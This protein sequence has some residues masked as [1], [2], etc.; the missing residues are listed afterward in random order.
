MKIKHCLF[1]CLAVFFSL[2][3]FAKID[4]LNAYQC[5]S[6]GYFMNVQAVSDGFVMTDNMSNALYLLQDGQVEKIVSAPGCGRYFT[7]SDDGKRIGFKMINETGQRPAV[8]HV[9][10]GNVEYLSEAVNLC[11]QPDFLGDAV[12][13]T[14]QNRL[15]VLPETGKAQTV[16][17]DNYSNLLQIS[18]NKSHLVFST[19]NDEL[20]LMDMQT[21]E[22]IQI[23]ETGKMSVYPQ[24]SPDGKKILFQSGEMFVYDIEENKRYSVGEGV[25]PKWSPNS[26]DI[27]F[28]KQLSKNEVLL[29]SDLFL[30][31]YRQGNHVALIHTSNRFEHYPVFLSENEVLFQTYDKNAIRILNLNSNTEQ[32]IYEGFDAVVQDFFTLNSEKSE[33]LIPGT[34]PYTHQVYDTPDEHY[35]YGSCAP[36]CA[37]M[38]I[39]YYNRLPKWPTDVTKLFPHSSDYGSYVSTKYR[40]NEHYFE[41]SSTT[42]GS[43]I[44]YGGYGYMWGLGSPNSQ[45]L[46]Y[47]ELHYFESSQ[48]WNSSIT[49]AGVIDEIDADYP[50]PM[51]AML[52]DAGHL[53]LTKGYI[54]DQHTLIF[55]EPYG[56]K[57][58]P[59]WP[60]Y[61]GH[62]AYYDWPGYNNGYQNLDH[63]G[64]YGVI[65]WTITAHTTETEYSNLVIDNDHYDHGFVM[66]NSENGSTQRYFRDV[67]DG[68]NNHAWYT[69]TMVDESDICYV[70]WIP[71]PEEEGF[72]EVSAFIPSTYADAEGAPY[73][74]VDANGEHTVILNQNDYS[75]EWVSLGTYHYQVG[76]EFYTYLGDST[77]YDGQSIAYDAVKYDYIPSPV[78][79]FESAGQD[80]CV[81]ESINFSNTSENA[82]TYTWTFDGADLLEGTDMNPV[83]VYNEAGVYDLSL[84]A[85]GVMETDTLTLSAYINVHEAPVADFSVSDNNLYLPNALAVFQN[86]SLYAYN[87]TWDFGDGNGSEDANPYHY[88]TEV[89]S[90]NVSLTASNPW[91]EDVI[92]SLEESIEV[93]DATNV[94]DANLMEVNVFPNPAT[95]RIQIVV[96]A[97]I[98]SVK[99]YDVNG[100]VVLQSEGNQEFLNVRG[101]AKGC[102]MLS[103]ETPKGVVRKQIVKE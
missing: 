100:S 8:Y 30:C 38:A 56:D 34:V 94:E 61:D 57:N 35:G 73:K 99:L 48:L 10:T 93:Q 84:L 16:L 51:C 47:L 12:Y 102:Y 76:S 31:D 101:L 55:S 19:S 75:D 32:L 27:V 36:T 33:D 80:F 65:A 18:P 86:E 49:W 43:D 97:E 89:G 17:L 58:T 90:F 87:Y 81:G 77:G 7:V 68:Y 95:D 6:K 72:Y 78:A 79:S 9:E 37:I 41:E 60:S 67:N 39:S 59:S 25:A 98:L 63:S 1:L 46:N 2:T 66:N 14:I 4:G 24:F 64:A 83:V 82:E 91:C 85:H 40:F 23:S 22:K 11:G 52:S 62:K 70:K 92:Y 71:T 88:Y 53:I 44:A 5:E 21:G 26:E 28:V 96:N 20:V 69:L 13:F 54:H 3:L 42:G 74:V 50:L 15:I 103:I 29:R 45:M